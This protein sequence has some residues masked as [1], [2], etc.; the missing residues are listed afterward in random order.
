MT[1][2]GSDG[3]R[4]SLSMARLDSHAKA[5]NLPLPSGGFGGRVIFRCALEKVVEQ[6]EAAGLLIRQG[7]IVDST[8]IQTPCSTKNKERK[9]D[10]EMHQSRKGNQWFFGMKCHVGVDKDSG[11]IHAMD[12]TAGNV[13]DVTVAAEL[14]H[15][16]EDVLYGD[17]GYQGLENREEMVGKQVERELWI[18]AHSRLGKIPVV[19]TLLGLRSLLQYTTNPTTSPSL[20]GLFGMRQSVVESMFR[21]SNSSRMG[22]R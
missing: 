15:G 22:R 13:S 16:Q 17:A 18:R 8:N 12:I 10:P 4:R 14:L 5:R 19:L 2:G 21:D 9:R 11:L 20:E 7:S 6:L 3:A 1:R